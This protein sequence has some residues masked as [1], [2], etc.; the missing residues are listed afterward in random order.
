MPLV[1]IDLRKGKTPEFRGKIGD[2]VYRRFLGATWG[3]LDGY[4]SRN[5]DALRIDPTIIF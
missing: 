5:F 3:M 1:R 4:P 2:M